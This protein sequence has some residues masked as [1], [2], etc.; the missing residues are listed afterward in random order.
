MKMSFVGIRRG[1]GALNQPAIPKCNKQG[2]YRGGRHGLIPCDQG[3][4]SRKVEG[5]N[6]CQERGKYVVC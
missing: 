1:A 5:L 6:Q 2:V 3:F 4:I